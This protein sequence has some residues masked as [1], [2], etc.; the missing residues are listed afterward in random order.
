MLLLLLGNFLF[1]VFPYFAC[2]LFKPYFT[3]KPQHPVFL[4][5]S[6]VHLT[7]HCLLYLIP[8]AQLTAS[9]KGAIWYMPGI[10]QIGVD[11]V[12]WERVL[13]CFYNY[14]A[15]Q[16]FVYERSFVNNLNN[17]QN[18]VITIYT[19]FI[20]YFSECSIF[21][22]LMVLFLGKIKYQIIHVSHH[23]GENIGQFET[24]MND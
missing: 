21:F 9:L 22:F 1:A 20:H 10:Q 5:L 12:K 16:I 4:F 14:F 8:E 17:M 2:F 19:W 3:Q 13:K 23:R 11:S 6:S 24:F 15:Y 18:S 7:R